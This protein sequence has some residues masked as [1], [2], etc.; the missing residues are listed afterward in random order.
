MN[1]PGHRFLTT[2]AL[3]AMLAMGGWGVATLSASPAVAATGTPR[4]PRTSRRATSKAPGGAL[5]SSAVC[6]RPG[7]IE[8]S[9]ATLV[10]HHKSVL[11]GLPGYNP[12]RTSSDTTSSNKQSALGGLFPAMTTYGYP[13]W[14]SGV[15]TPAGCTTAP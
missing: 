12:S 8:G 5:S 7:A 4:A 11:V 6:T 2:S 13:S 3:I 10:T 14:N 1:G 9:Q 15:G